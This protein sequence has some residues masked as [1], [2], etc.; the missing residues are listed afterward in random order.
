MSI[1]EERK[2]SVLFSDSIYEDQLGVIV[3]KLPTEV[4]AAAAGVGKD[5]TDVS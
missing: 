4:D 1:T 2:K 5:K 3:L